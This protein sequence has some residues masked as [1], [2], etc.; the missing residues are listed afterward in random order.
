MRTD[1]TIIISTSNAKEAE[2]LAD[3]IAIMESGF[4]LAHGTPTYLRNNIGKV[5]IFVIPC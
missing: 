5:L 2:S 4:V 3:R 1:R